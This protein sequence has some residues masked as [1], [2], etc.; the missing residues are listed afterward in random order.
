MSKTTQTARLVQVTYID[1][2]MG[3]RLVLSRTLAPAPI[4]AWEWIESNTLAQ[5]LVLLCLAAVVAAQL[6]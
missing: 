1:D 5:T 4:R 2:G 6:R 3:R